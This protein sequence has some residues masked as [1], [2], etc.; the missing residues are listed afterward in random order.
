MQV[1]GKAEHE[2]W[3]LGIV[4]AA[5]TDASGIGFATE[6]YV[7]AGFCFWIFCFAMS[8]YSIYVERKLGGGRRR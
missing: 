6:G 4:K 7:F 3:L 8:R 1:L 2:N 5:L